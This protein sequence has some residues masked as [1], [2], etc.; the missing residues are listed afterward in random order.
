[1]AQSEVV[2]A[3]KALA[4]KVLKKPAVLDAKP[5]PVK[6][7]EEPKREPVLK[8]VVS[9]NKTAPTPKPAPKPI[10]KVV[11]QKALIASKAPDKPVTNKPVANKRKE[12]IIQ[13]VIKEDGTEFKR[14]LTTQ[15]MPED[16]STMAP[17]P[18]TKQAIEMNSNMHASRHAEAAISGLNA[19]FNGR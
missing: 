17:T 6:R 18:V 13:T 15:S 11:S 10:P 5:L 4:A 12:R 2:Q 3:L 1:L 14:D 19:A 7:A 9:R 16:K 8:K